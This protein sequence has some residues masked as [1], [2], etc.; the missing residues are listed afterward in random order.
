MYRDDDADNNDISA[1]F[2]SSTVFHIAADSCSRMGIT[3]TPGDSQRSISIN[4][5]GRTFRG[6][7]S[8]N[9]QTSSSCSANDHIGATALRRDIQRRTTAQVNSAI[10]VP[11]FNICM[12]YLHTSQRDGG[13]GVCRNH[14]PV[15]GRLRRPAV[16]RNGDVRVVIDREDTVRL[17]VAVGLTG[18]LDIPGCRSGLRRPGGPRSQLR[19]ARASDDNEGQR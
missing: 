16:R 7:N 4:C 9:R 1:A 18:H 19:R 8:R 11:N 6:M 13:G 2:A 10:S 5:E 3:S 15:R 12:R 17:G 14:D